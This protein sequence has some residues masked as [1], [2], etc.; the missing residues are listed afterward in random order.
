MSSC[1]FTLRANSTAKYSVR[2]ECSRGG[3]A[4]TWFL[5]APAAAVLL[6]DVVTKA[7]MRREFERGQHHWLIDGW[8]GM[9]RTENRGVAFGVGAESSL[10]TVFVVI[11]IGILA[12]LMLRSDLMAGPLGGI[13]L[14]LT[15]GGALG[16]LIDRV[17]DGT[18]TDFLV[19]GPW[20]RF[21]IADS[22]LTLGLITL[23][24]AEVRTTV[25]QAQ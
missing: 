3:F 5:I 4:R 11:G 17:P 23:V 18:V 6:V 10:V 1:L 21:N 12:L 8:V 22:A 14:G 13:A 7:V 20:P 16:N 9:Q 25:R 2:H 15:A 24:F 19:L